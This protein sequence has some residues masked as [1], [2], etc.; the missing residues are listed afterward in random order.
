[1][2]ISKLPGYIKSNSTICIISFLSRTMSQKYSSIT[3]LA[4]IPT[5]SDLYKSSRLQAP[6]PDA[7]N[8]L[9]SSTLNS[10][11][12]LIQTSITTLGVTCI[13]NAANTYLLGGAGV[14][15]LSLNDP[16]YPIHPSFKIPPANRLFPPGWRHSLSRRARPP[17]RMQN[18]K[19]LHH[20]LG[21]ADFGL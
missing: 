8:P 17:R 14:V 6:L 9:P 13:V 5:L 3:P 2:L 10:K 1:M 18:L 12:S 15:R 4:S 19:W 20:R 11:I 16:T 7:S 21:E